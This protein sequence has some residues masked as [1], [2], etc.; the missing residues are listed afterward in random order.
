MAFSIP[1]TFFILFLCSFCFSLEVFF[2][3]Y[4]LFFGKLMFSFL[5]LCIIQEFINHAKANCLAITKMGSEFKSQDI[6]CGLTHVGWFFPNLL[7][8]SHRQL[9]AGII[10]LLSVYH[11]SFFLTAWTFSLTSLT[12][13]ISWQLSSHRAS[14]PGERKTSERVGPKWKLQS[15]IT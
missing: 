8:N 3:P 13:L 4:R 7:L 6:W 11:S 10:S 9:L 15:F 14:N 1:L 5:F 2:F 12:V